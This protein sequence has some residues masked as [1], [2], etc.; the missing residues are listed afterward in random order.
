M[1]VYATV[2]VWGIYGARELM[3]LMS[4]A[5]ENRRRTAIWCTVSLQCAL[6]QLVLAKRLIDS[7]RVS[8]RPISFAQHC[9][10]SCR[11]SSSSS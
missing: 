9:G 7:S 1:R 11:P 5:P 2:G 6:T 4:W 10:W 3:R 8:S